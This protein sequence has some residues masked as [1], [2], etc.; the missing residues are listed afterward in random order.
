MLSLVSECQE[1]ECGDGT[2]L[3]VTFAGELLGAS[4]GLIRMGL[5]TSE[6]GGG[7]YHAAVKKNH[8][9]GMERHTAVSFIET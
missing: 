4:E 1:V 8:S 7:G 6:I 5:H 9:V 2:N 3:T